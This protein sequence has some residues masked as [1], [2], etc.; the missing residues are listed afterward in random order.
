MEEIKDKDKLFIV[1][2]VNVSKISPSSINSV[3][4]HISESMKYDDT[5]NRIIIPI[6]NGE[7]KVECINPKLLNEDQYKKVKD[8]LF[9]IENK[10]NSFINSD[11]KEM[12]SDR[13]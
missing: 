13:N 7:T 4:K 12:E 2:Y 8:Q 6:F 9:E 3:L 11:L 5:I 10:F 1:F